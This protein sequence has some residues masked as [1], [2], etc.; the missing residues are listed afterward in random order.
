MVMQNPLILEKAIPISLDQPSAA[1]SARQPSSYQG[2]GVTLA[3]ARERAGLALGDVA[4]KTRIRID[5]LEALEHG[6]FGEL[7]GRIYAVGFIKSYASCLGLDPLLA[8]ETYKLESAD[9][10]APEKL[11]FPAAIPERRTPSAKLVFAALVAS[12][13]VAFGAWDILGGSN[14]PKDRVPPVPQHLAEQINKPPVTAEAPPPGAPGAPSDTLRAAAPLGAPVASADTTPAA[15]PP[16]TELAVLAVPVPMP[17]PPVPANFR[18]MEIAPRAPLAAATPVAAM[19]RPAID[20]PAA[21]DS[22][23]TEASETPPP[24]RSAAGLNSTRGPLAAIAPSDPAGA[25]VSA[26]PGGRV[27][28]VAKTDTWLQIQGGGQAPLLARVLRAGERY[29]VPDVAG[30]MLT[31][32]DAAALE[33]TVDGEVMPPLGAPGVVRR[34]IPLDPERLRAASIP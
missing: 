21:N 29:S 6:Q 19:P 1:P 14:L 2:I 16:P 33:V 32:S 9:L 18:P 13:L 22:G 8:V 24:P 15:A 27:I 5:Y 3:R 25:Q 26:L 20:R 34:N 28:I 17:K 10:G 23:E 4:A 12:A 11:V 30:L 7:P 31:A